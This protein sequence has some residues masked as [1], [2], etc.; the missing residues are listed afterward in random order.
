MEQIKDCGYNIIV[1]L[2]PMLN[3]TVDHNFTDLLKWFIDYEVGVSIDELKYA[4]VIVGGKDRDF[5]IINDLTNLIQFWY[6][7]QVDFF[8]GISNQNNTKHMCWCT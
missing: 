4:P 2:N 3:Y 5:S 8:R 6:Y 7:D 1:D